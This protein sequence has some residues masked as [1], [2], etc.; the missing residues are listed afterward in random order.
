[1]ADGPSES[2]LPVDRPA[3][4]VQAVWCVPD[5][6]SGAPSIEV[7]P[8]KEEV[9][10]RFLLTNAPDLVLSIFAGTDFPGWHIVDIAELH[11][12]LFP[13][14]SAATLEEMLP[15]AGPSVTPCRRLWNLWQTC[16][17]RLDALPVWALE[18][19]SIICREREEEGLAA[20]FARQALAA[21]EGGSRTWTTSFPSVT[22]HVERNP[23]PSLSDCTALD[24]E[25]VASRLDRDGALSKLVPGYEPR[26]GQLMMLKAVVEAFN[27]GKHLVVEAG[28]G[29]G[30]SLAY[31]LPAA[32]WARLNDVPVIVS[33][34]TKNLQTQLVEKDLP[35]VLNLLAADRSFPGAPLLE[36]AV[37][38]GRSNYLCL[39]RLGHLIEEAQFELSRP[40][41]RLFAQT[42][43][44]AT[45]TPDGD[46]D[47]LLGGASIDPAFV[48]L[49]TS[50]SD[51]CLGRSCK[52]YR[53]CF[54]Q[55]ARAR[56]LKAK[57][58]VANHALVFTELD[59]ETPVSLPQSAQI[60]FDEAHNLEEAATRFF[61]KEFSP[62]RVARIQKRL[63]QGRGRSRRGV[64]E[65]LSK[66]VESGAIGTDPQIRDFLRLAID[67]AE[68]EV[69]HLQQTGADVFHA[70]HGFLGKDDAPY[71]YDGR[72]TGSVTSDPVEE[73]ED[74]EDGPFSDLL[75]DLMDDE[76]GKKKE[77]AEKPRA[78]DLEALRGN[79][80]TREL[81]SS[82]E[83]SG[84]RFAQPSSAA[85]RPCTDPRWK[86]V[87]KTFA[88][89]RQAL[90][91]LVQSLEEIAGLLQIDTQDE[92]D[93][94]SADTTDVDHAIKALDELYEDAMVVLAGDQED[95]VFWI[96]HVRGGAALAMAC[97]APLNVGP[98]LAK[99]L[100]E[101]R[102]SVILCSATLRVAGHYKYI[103]SRLGFDRVDQDRLVFCNAPSPFDYL[104][105]CSLLVPAYLPEPADL[106]C[107]LARRFDGRTLVLFTSYEMM[108]QCAKLVGPTLE[109]DGIS[110]LRQGES[111]SR[112]LIT[113]VFRKGK[114]TVLFGTQ[115][116]WEGVDVV[117]SALSCVI[118]A[119]LPFVSP[120][121]PIFSAR[122]E[123]LE[124]QGKSSFG[125]LSLPAAVLRLR[126][127]FG[128]LIRHRDDR[129]CVVIADTRVLTKRYGKTFLNSLPT[130]YKAC[131][132]LAALLEE[133]VVP[134]KS[135]AE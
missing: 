48:P 95:Y 51:E 98:F 85:P 79:E 86:K 49:I 34:N 26:P 99:N 16:H 12:I 107:R 2:D 101:K 14:A 8:A 42:L 117:G 125:L 131:P 53:R 134:G 4:Q 20:L 88:A 25:E 74:D 11:R 23:L 36:A 82:L 38:K 68:E 116:F 135:G 70:L 115:S 97:A 94:G 31:L 30:K 103:S 106:V 13:G 113:R 87:Q 73:K 105:Q 18:N 19:I 6:K 128:R 127:G 108:R 81:A 33:T 69:G 41:L 47:A 56:A 100:F 45:T 65:N 62:S 44:W 109:D 7:W 84:R 122:C 72:G 91:G 1:M 22:T 118:V 35:A 55:K 58:V 110:L 9:E 54:V 129:G 32:M 17:G 92:L 114:R 119:R 112:N 28:T 21:G 76:E 102:E 77:G 111:G 57:L 96:E 61:T 5:A 71:R 90:S 50:S 29:I 123:Q 67:L 66:R 132:D 93:L 121:D 63:F 78:I 40:E 37:I 126:Q 60:V 130:S 10:E 46:L 52:F 27:E 104:T 124:A 80:K 59:T 120:T 89:F 3:F 15:P 133:C 24:P 43:A 39:R 75:L 64:L 83:E